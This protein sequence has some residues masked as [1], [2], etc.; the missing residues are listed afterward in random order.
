MNSSNRNG[1]Y[2][3]QYVG[4]L[5][6]VA[7]HL[8]GVKPERIDELS[9]I[10]LNH[11]PS[12][13]DELGGRS[14]LNWNGSPLQ[15]LI[16]VRNQHPVF[17]LIG[18]P[19]FFCPDPLMRLNKS[20]D[21]LQLVLETGRA[22]ALRD[23][24]LQ[25]LNSILPEDIRA[26]R[27]YSHGMTWLAR[28]LSGSGAALYVLAV[29]NMSLAW[30]KAYEWAESIFTDPKEVQR[31]ITTLQPCCRLL[32]V[33]IEG[34]DFKTGRAKIYWRLTRPSYPSQFGID[35]YDDPT[36]I[37]FLGTIMK[38]HPF[39]LY[40]VTFSAGFSLATGRLI[41]VKA[42]VSNR[43]AK[44]TTHEAIDLVESQAET[45]G[46]HCP[47]LRD[48]LSVLPRESVIVGFVGLGL[49]SHGHHRL[50]VYLY[51]AK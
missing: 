23:V 34:R 45:L 51:Q 43:S 42:D 17:R 33:G 24:C 30:R 35:L 6:H 7:Q 31:T 5:L 44:L 20:I 27:E 37:R 12:R 41:D 19:A 25:S 2:V 15:F 1:D 39:S 22:G 14:G 32:F 40:A 4:D 29:A 11:P 46:L 26:L 36:L 18:D 21:A 28:P 38:D 8:S 13:A 9:R 49:D 48:A 50:N 16:S 47:L 10:L 3:A